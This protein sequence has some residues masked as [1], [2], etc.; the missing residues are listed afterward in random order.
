MTVTNILSLN[1]TK[2]RKQQVF[3]RLYTSSKF[4]RAIDSSVVDENIRT[5][6]VDT[7][8]ILFRDLRIVVK[9]TQISS[10]LAPQRTIEHLN[11]FVL[12]RSIVDLSDEYIVTEISLDEVVNSLTRKLDYLSRSH[13]VSTRRN[14]DLLILVDI[15]NCRVLSKGIKPNIS[16]YQSQ[17]WRSISV[18]IDRLLFILYAS[19]RA[20]SWFRHNTN[21]PFV[22]PKL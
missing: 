17:G 20:P 15:K 21:R 1:K 19:D 6:I 8:E 13:S 4:L 14:Q 5:S 12:Q 16:I 2:T 10:S 22:T 18:I 7:N 11:K 3:K 9:D